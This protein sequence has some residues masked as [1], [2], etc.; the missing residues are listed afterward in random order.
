MRKLTRMESNKISRQILNRHGVDL[1]YCTMSCCG[2]EVRLTGWLCR[3]DGSDFSMQQV[4]ALIIDFRRHLPT[5][6]VI[7]ELENWNFTSDHIRRI[8]DDSRTAK[9]REDEEAEIYEINLE[10]YD[11]EDVS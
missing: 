9:Q 4:E 1:A 8:D 5:Y 6:W 2:H 7:G 3:T 10:D 11:L